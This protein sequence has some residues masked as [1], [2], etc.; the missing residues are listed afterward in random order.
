MATGSTDLSCSPRR[1][2]RRHRA[3]LVERDDLP[4]I[5]RPR[6]GGHVEDAPAPVKGPPEAPHPASLTAVSLC[7][8]LQLLLSGPEVIERTTPTAGASRGVPGHLDQD[9]ERA[10]SRTAI[11]NRPHDPS[12]RRSRAA[13]RFAQRQCP[14][15]PA[16]RAAAAED[17]ERLLDRADPG[18]RQTPVI[19][20]RAGI[21]PTSPRARDRGSLLAEPVRRHQLAQSFPLID[22]PDPD[23]PWRWRAGRITQAPEPTD[24]P[25]QSK[26][27][28][29]RRDEHTRRAS[30]M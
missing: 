13:A 3:T 11:D 6:T 24:R 21:R 12:R 9:A 22:R 2:P 7:L 8:L 1:A 30:A 26:Y 17:R 25:S 4:V 23:R 28:R 15:G 5:E 10:S 18:K 19:V 27:R 20:R 29:P 16:R 14:V